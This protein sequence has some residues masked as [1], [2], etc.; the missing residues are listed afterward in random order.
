ME[1]A[2][3]EQPRPGP[4]TDVPEAA[5]DARWW[6]WAQLVWIVPVIAVVI[7]GWLGVR[8]V[9]S[10]GPTIEIT[11]ETAS[12]LEANKTSVKY[13]DVEVGTVTSIRLSDD[14]SRVVVS[15]RLTPQARDLVVKDTKF[16]VVRPR[17]AGGQALGL[18]TILSGAY[19]ALDP[20]QSKESHRRFEGLE[21]PPAVTSDAR[22]R[23]FILR[24]EDLGSIDVGSPVYFRRVRV[25]QI[26]SAALDAEGG[27]VTFRAFVNHPHQQFVTT[28]SRFW[29]ASGIDLSLDARGLRLE[30]QSLLSIAI[31]GVAFEEPPDARAGTPAS[32]EAEF[33][34]YADRET[35]LRQPPKLRDRYILY[36]DQSVRGLGV[37]AP[38]DFRGVVIG[39][40]ARVSLDYNRA[41]G[42]LRPAVEINIYPERLAASLREPAAALEPGE[43]RAMWRRF[44]ERGLRAQLR[45][46]NLIT[47]NLYVTLDL[48]PKERPV[49]I[50]AA[51][52]P[53]EI[54]TLPGGFEELQTSVA[55]VMK[56][57]ERV[58]FNEIAA[59]LRKTVNTLDGTLIEVSSLVTK[60]GTEIA[61]ELREALKE[62]RATLDRAQQVL[63]QDSPVQ[64]DLR[65]TLRD[66]SRAAQSMRNLADY[67]ERHPESIIRGRRGESR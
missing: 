64:G 44:I 60:L 26:V 61:P 25:G 21:A 13:K 15:A 52:E 11:F 12:G 62:A 42:S 6:R 32:A 23:Q 63:A 17:I 38:V 27:G 9:L 48:F 24:A 39:D 65:A 36:F 55:N 54:P 40:V 34:L 53:M 35:A 19:I 22:G 7:A 43:R 66:V 3:P 29:N 2:M 46:A 1:P 67:L 5:A 51:A 59:D 10:R 58:P 20:G 37:G 33:T 18:G 41:R 31:G 57:L 30:T 4:E 49:K 50:G 14:R 8:S 28:S 47:G 16:W 56:K 45:T